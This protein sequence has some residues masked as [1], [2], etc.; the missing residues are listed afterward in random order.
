M[1]VEITGLRDPCPQIE[2]PRRG[3]RRSVLYGR[4]RSDRIVQRKAGIIGIVLGGKVDV[5]MR[6]LVEPAEGG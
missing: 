6:I 2:K 5:G 1:M 4:R 3:C